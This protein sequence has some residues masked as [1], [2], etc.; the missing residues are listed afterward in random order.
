VNGLLLLMLMLQL[1]QSLPIFHESGVPMMPLML[2]L[3]LLLLLL[4][5]LLLPLLLP[6]TAPARS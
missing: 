2:H 6:T 1:R 3:P 4:L 5:L